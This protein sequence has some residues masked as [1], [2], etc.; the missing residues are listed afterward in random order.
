MLGGGW[1]IRRG[2]HNILVDRSPAMKITCSRGG[3]R[4]AGPALGATRD[5]N[6]KSEGGHRRMHGIELQARVI[7]LVVATNSK[8]QNRRCMLK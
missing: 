1:D 6:G 8:A 3:R 2:L 4:W 5:V 7:T